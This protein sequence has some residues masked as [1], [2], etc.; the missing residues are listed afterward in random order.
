MTR[1]S[2]IR[3]FLLPLVLLCAAAFNYTQLQGT[4]LVRPIHAVSLFAMGALFAVLV[5]NIVRVL[6]KQP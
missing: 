2:A 5:M 3:G 1:P 4:E 6:R